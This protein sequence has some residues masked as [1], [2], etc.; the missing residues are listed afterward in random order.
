[1]VKYQC[2]SRS[3]DTVPWIWYFIFS[4]ILFT[5]QFSSEFYP[6]LFTKRLINYHDPITSPVLTVN[7]LTHICL[8]LF[9][10]VALFRLGFAGSPQPTKLACQA[11]LGEPA[12]PS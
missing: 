8:V 11:K 10:A 12:L 7:T 6:D 3:L 5:L 4:F 2:P 1:L 9:E